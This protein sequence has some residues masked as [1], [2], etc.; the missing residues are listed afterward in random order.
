M[1]T[2]NLLSIL[3][4]AGVL[5]F[6][7]CKKDDSGPLTKEEATTKLSSTNSDF[8]TIST[9]YKNTQ[10]IQVQESL[11][12]LTLPF[13]GLPQKTKLQNQE[14]LLKEIKSYASN[15][16]CFK[17]KV[18]NS[19]FDFKEYVGTWEY[20]AANPTK[21]IFT[22]NSTDKVILKFPHKSTTNNVTLTYYDF[23][24]SPL[25][26]GTVMTGLKAKMEIAGQTIWS[27]E[28][29]ATYNSILDFNIK[30]TVSVGIFNV[31][32]EYDFAMTTNQWVVNASSI[33]KKSGSVVYSTTLKAVYTKQSET[34]ITV[35]VDAKVVVMSIEIRYKLSFNSANMQNVQ[36]LNPNDILTMSIYTT[37]GDKVADLKF[38]QNA[39][40]QWVL[41]I[42]FTNGEKALAETY[43]PSF[44]KDIESFFWNDLFEMDNGL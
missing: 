34:S 36:S 41:W 11:D 24:E 33:I 26:T 3:A 23:K 15:N 8:S 38:E 17:S 40:K 44:V 16:Q 12:G 14:S 4:I 28:Y 25:L 37:G 13:D 27:W 32:N 20:D 5:F 10:G 18:A 7:S 39:D 21:W 31:S 43:M 29:S 22:A 9:E 30:T 2:K 42:Y 6:V 35:V 19:Y 1:R